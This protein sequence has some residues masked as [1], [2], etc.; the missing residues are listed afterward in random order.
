LSTLLDLIQEYATL[1]E[2]KTVARG[3]LPPALEAR[4][5][6][7]KR[8]YDLLMAQDGLARAPASRFSAA[9]IRE[10]V[11]SRGR[12]RVETELEIVVAHGASYHRARVSNLSRGGARIHGDDSFGIG[13]ELTLH[14]ASISRGD[15]VLPAAGRVR[16]QL[17]R[18]TSDGGFRYN[19]GVQFCDLDPVAEENLDAFVVD[20]LEAKLLCLGKESLDPDFL[21]REGVEL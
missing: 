6:E 1:N 14:M 8:F 4:W 13:E 19:T 12:L 11:A 15:S 10:R 3:V 21:R 20:C 16:W 7:V 5:A 18:G 17:D 9:E 2:A